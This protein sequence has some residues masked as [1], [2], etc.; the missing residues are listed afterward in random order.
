MSL[1]VICGSLCDVYCVSLV[2]VVCRVFCMLAVGRLLFVGCCLE[3]VVVCLLYAR[4]SKFLVC[5][6]LCVLVC[7]T[8][9]RLLWLYVVVVFLG[10]CCLMC[11]V[12]CCVLFVVMV[13]C[14]LS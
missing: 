5:C 6:L 12:H 14:L 9:A 2:V 11:V 7:C 13:C 3:V 8:V 10:C 1:F 4:C